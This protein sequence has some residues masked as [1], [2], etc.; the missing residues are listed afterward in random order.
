MARIPLT[1]QPLGSLTAGPGSSPP[2]PVSVVFSDASALGHSFPNTGREQVIFKA[3]SGS[4]TLTIVSKADQFGRTGDQVIPIT[5]G[6]EVFAGPFVPL[7]N[8]GDGVNVFADPSLL[9]GSVSI[10]V[11][12]A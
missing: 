6:Q 11:I 12:K 9:S 3:G 5:A 2:T 1:V 10:A 4:G 7:V 8:W